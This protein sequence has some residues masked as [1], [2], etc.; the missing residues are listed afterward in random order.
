MPSPR[1]SLIALEG[2]PLI[3]PGDDLASHI[4]TALDRNGITLVDAD[5]LVVTQKIVSKAEDRYVAL[6]DV[7]PSRRAR[8]LAAETGKDPRVVEVIL[9]E[10]VRVVRHRPNLIIVEHR[11]GYVMANAGIDES[12]ID[13]GMGERVLRLPRDPDAAAERL[14]KDLAG[15]YECDPAVIVNDSFGRPWRRGVAGVALGAAGL[16]SLLD[17][18]GQP[19]LFGRPLK[20]TQ[21]G[22]ADEIAAAASLLMGQAAEGL[23]VVLVRGLR[24]SA[25]DA[26]ASTLLRPESEDLFR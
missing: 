23:P 4:A 1:L 7:E 26:P 9:S 10:S 12:N 22:F 25:T 5:I 18:R 2:L 14:R 16:P 24:W 11:R 15:R 21:V 3:H 19:D 20:V 6:D 8:D 13:H 17:L